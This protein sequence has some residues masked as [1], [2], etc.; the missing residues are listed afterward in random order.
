MVIKTREG[1]CRL[2]KEGKYTC[3]DL[4]M[5]LVFGSP[6]VSSMWLLE[7]RCV[8]SLDTQECEVWLGRTFYKYVKI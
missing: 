5:S 1:Y 4:E 8:V 2:T 3:R 6:S 7:H